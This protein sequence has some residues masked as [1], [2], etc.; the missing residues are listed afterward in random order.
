M[1]I[2]V[3]SPLSPSYSTIQ[4]SINAVWSAK[5]ADYRTMVILNQN[6]GFSAVKFYDISNCCAGSSLS[7]YINV[8]ANP[9]GAAFTSDGTTLYIAD[10]D[11]GLV[12]INTTILSSPVVAGVLALP[13]FA[14]H[15]A[16][17]SS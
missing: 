9:Q 7:G 14:R 16:V 12:M 5:T 2:S 10:G 6:A 11:G 15:V 3:T 13:G 8:S 17:T 4:S 1:W